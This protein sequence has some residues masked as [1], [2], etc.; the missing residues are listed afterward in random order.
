MMGA[1]K[2][3]LKELKNSIEDHF[4]KLKFLL[5]EDINEVCFVFPNIF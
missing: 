4:W 2:Q 5:K 3:K 1:M